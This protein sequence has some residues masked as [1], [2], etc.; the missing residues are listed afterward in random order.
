[1]CKAGVVA[2]INLVSKVPSSIWEREMPPTVRDSFVHTREP[3]PADYHVVY[4]IR[5]ALELP[6]PP[7]RLI[8]VASEP[9]EIREY[10]LNI[11]RQYGLIVGAGFPTVSALPHFRRV[12]GIAPWWVGVSSSTETHYETSEG[13]ISLTRARLLALDEPLEDRLS[14]IMSTKARTPD[15]V[16]RIRL[17]EYLASKISDIAVF[18]V[19]HNPVD[20]KADVLSRFRY[21]LA[22][23]NSAHPGYWT[24]KLADPILTRCFTFYGGHRSYREDFP[25]N[26]IQLIDPYEP[27]KVYRIVSEA[28]E[29]GAWEKASEGRNLHKESVLDEHSFHRK[30]ASVISTLSPSSTGKSVSR[31]KA[32]HPQSR[33]K[34]FVDPVYRSVTRP[35]P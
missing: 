31:I 23:E 7:E 35:N 3:V 30:I 18:G 5:D 2:V 12:T 13:E 6:N 33:W 9:P 22:V 29:K 4:G 25:G 34:K 21:H 26:G 10:N 20:D 16:Q 11:L 24:E 32:Q 14:V 1:M 28:L 8:F 15:Q 17:V 19:G 27:E